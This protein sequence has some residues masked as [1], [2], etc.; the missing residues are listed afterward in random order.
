MNRILVWAT[1][2]AAFL[3]LVVPVI[4]LTFKVWTHLD[5]TYELDEQWYVDD[6]AW[7]ESIIDRQE[8]IEKELNY[9]RGWIDG[10]EKRTFER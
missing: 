9:I 2:V 5:D 6:K 8:R 1:V 10:T 7:N 4:G 3:T